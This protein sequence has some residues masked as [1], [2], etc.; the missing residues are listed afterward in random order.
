MISEEIWKIV[1]ENLTKFPYLEGILDSLTYTQSP[2]TISK[3]IVHI[4]D[5]VQDFI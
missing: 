1:K 5:S 3:L 2:E 4:L